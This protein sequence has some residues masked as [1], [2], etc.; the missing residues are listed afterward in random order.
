MLAN[1]SASRNMAKQNAERNWRTKC[2]RIRELL[3]TRERQPIR[4]HAGTRAN[5]GQSK[6]LQ[7]HSRAG[8]GTL[9][10][11]KATVTKNN[12]R[13]TKY[14]LFIIYTAPSN[15]VHFIHRTSASVLRWHLTKSSQLIY[16]LNV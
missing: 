7:E 2:Q 1:Q 3:G 16:M 15:R 12:Y 11:T 8:T 14:I 5:A 9:T 13:S 10:R 6:G 4:M